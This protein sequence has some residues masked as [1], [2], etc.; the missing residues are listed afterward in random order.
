M[1]VCLYVCV[2]MSVCL[3]GGEQDGPHLFQLSL[4]GLG[5]LLP[6]DEFLHRAVQLHPQILV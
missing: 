3:Q 4:Q 2:W 5:V 1:C 6:P